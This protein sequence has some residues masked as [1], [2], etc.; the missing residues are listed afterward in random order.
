MRSRLIDDAEGSGRFVRIFSECL[1]IGA[2]LF[3]LTIFPALMHD[4][5]FDINR[6]KVQS[7]LICFSILFPLWAG[8][9]LWLLIGKDATANRI[10]LNQPILSGVVFLIVCFLSA[11]KSGWSSAVLWG[12][13]GRYSGLFFLLACGMV[14]L[15]SAAFVFRKY[16]QWLEVVRFS[17]L[18]LALLGILN[19]LG[20]DPFGF[21]IGIRKG[22]EDYFVST[23]GNTDFFGAWLAMLYAFCTRP[24]RDNVL[25]K[26]RSMIKNMPWAVILP[27]AVVASRSDGAFG[28]MLLICLIRI[29]LSADDW[30]ELG[31]C[32]LLTAL[33]WFSLPVMKS[34]LLLGRFDI[35]LKGAVAYAC[36]YRIGE[37]LGLVHFAAFYLCTIK[38]HKGEKTLDRAVCLKSLGVFLGLC[39]LIVLGVLFYF[40]ALDT[41]SDLGFASDLLRFND[42]WGSRRGFVWKRALRAFSDFPWNDK[43]FGRGIDST[44]AILTPYFDNP[45]MLAYG[46]FNDA[47][48]QPLQFLITTGILGIAAILYFHFSLMVKV[49][50]NVENN[51]D[52]IEDFATLCGYT[53]LSMV[54]VS[55]PILLATY[56]CIAGLSLSRLNEKE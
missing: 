7:L 11:A 4:H 32:L 1:S 19:I 30:E 22:Q 40:S 47:H 24:K 52:C 36:R 16:G 35:R 56:A 8:T 34:L 10:K 38:H 37:V 13:E 3:T 53:V 20:R 43:L 12:T 55:Q 28:A 15:M 31:Y 5:Y 17:T 2:V 39:I 49:A 54:C 25:L 26:K 33:L 44:K 41:S 51:A 46:V 21:Y 50:R 48:N 18:A 42:N 9:K 6:F 27:M 29:V 23:I 14:F 45:V